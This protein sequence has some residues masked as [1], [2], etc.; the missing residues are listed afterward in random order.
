MRKI[1]LDFY[2]VV[3]EM[4]AADNC[5]KEEG[6]VTLAKTPENLLQNYKELVH[7]YI[8][9]KLDM[10][11]G[12]VK[13]LDGIYDAL[14]EIMDPTAIG[15]FIP[16]VDFD[17]L[18]IDLMMYLDQVRNVFLEAEADNGEYLAVIMAESGAALPEEDPDEELV[19]L[20]KKLLGGKTL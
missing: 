6:V 12:S 7:D 4:T 14:T 17:D 18:S 19:D 2:D 16:T 13:T 20:M 15:F 9:E 5:N 8:A 3:E 11:V 10:P 1:I